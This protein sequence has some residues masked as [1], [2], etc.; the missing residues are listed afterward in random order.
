MVA[1]PDCGSKRLLLLDVDET[2]IFGSEN[3][4]DRVADFRVGHYHVYR[5]PFLKEFLEGTSAWYEL[6]IWSS[7]TLDYVSAVA[8]SIRP[9]DVRWQFIW[10]RDRC[11]QRMHA[12]R[13]EIDYIK[14]LKK[15]KRLGYDLDHVLFVDDTPTKL[16]RNY[17]NAIYVNSFVG[18]PSDRELQILLQFLESVRNASS[19]R[20]MEKRGWRSHG[21]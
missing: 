12:E 20:T 16:A 3:E 9:P 14:D 17:G 1:M 21:I 13:F 18:E 5:R 8:E 15:V 19:Y 7:A 11:T 10:G 2:L 4:L 6:A